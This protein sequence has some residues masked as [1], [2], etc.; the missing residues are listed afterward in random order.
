MGLLQRM[1]HMRICIQG[2][3]SRDS[4]HILSD[5]GGSG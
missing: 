4:E 5:N 1:S 2:M 3:L